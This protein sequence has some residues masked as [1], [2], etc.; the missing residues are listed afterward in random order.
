MTAEYVTVVCDEVP[1]DV[2]LLDSGTRPLD[3]TQVVR[4]LTG[5]SLRRSKVLVGQAPVVILDGI[6]EETAEAAATALR[7][8]GAQAE[9]RQRPEPHAADAFPHD[10][11]RR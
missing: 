6:P 1:K 5:L 7:D 10:P 11:E 8:A 3:V 4:R 9:T 2:I